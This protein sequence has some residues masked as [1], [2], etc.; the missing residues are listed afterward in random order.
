MKKYYKIK[1]LSNEKYILSLGG[2]EL[3]LHKWLFFRYNGFRPLDITNKRIVVTYPALF[4]MTSPI[5][6]FFKKED[7]NKYKQ[8]PGFGLM[9]GKAYI[10]RYSI[11]KGHVFG[12]LAPRA[13]LKLFVKRGW[14]TYTIKIYTED[15]KKIEKIIKENS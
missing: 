9:G 13:C 7:Y 3:Y 1:L 12:D 2:V 8:S 10:I 15:Y 11:D 6:Y 5:N 4:R 14:V